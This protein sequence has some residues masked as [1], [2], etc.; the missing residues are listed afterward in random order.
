MP[1]ALNVL[2][3]GDFGAI[4]DRPMS[5][6]V[7]CHRIPFFSIALLLC[8]LSPR[9]PNLDDFRHKESTFH[10]TFGILTLALARPFS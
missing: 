1:T 8:R 6:N 10:Y 5:P 4:D 7:Q 9:F 3:L 2:F